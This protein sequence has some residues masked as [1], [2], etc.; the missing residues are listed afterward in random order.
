MSNPHDCLCG[1]HTFTF[2]QI[3][4]YAGRSV[5]FINR[6]K[7]DNLCIVYKLYGIL[8]LLLKN[9]VL[10]S[11]IIIQIMPTKGCDKNA[12]LKLDIYS[13]NNEASDSYEIFLSHKYHWPLSEN[14]F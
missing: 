4:Q 5:V 8:N 10:R 6:K 7:D 1:S 12:R 2:S 11:I 13:L 3:C 9:P 14:L